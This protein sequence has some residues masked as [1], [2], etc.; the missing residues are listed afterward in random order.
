MTEHGTAQPTVTLNSS[1]PPFYQSLLTR[2][3][4]APA[5]IVRSAALDI[6]PGT[7]DLHAKKST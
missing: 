4:T 3:E 2:V 6:D 1:M 5:P 7:P